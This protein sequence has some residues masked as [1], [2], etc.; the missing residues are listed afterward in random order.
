MQVLD[1][2]MLRA[3][4]DGT[5]EVVVDF[6]MLVNMALSWYFTKLDQVHLITIQ[7]LNHH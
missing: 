6:I 3:Y 4:K 2:E 7:C 5:S 1:S